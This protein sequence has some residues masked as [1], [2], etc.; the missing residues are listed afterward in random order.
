MRFALEA[1]RVAARARPGH[2]P[3]VVA[4]FAER[5]AARRYAPGLIGTSQTELSRLQIASGRS[6]YLRLMPTEEITMHDIDR[7]QLEY[8]QEA[9]PFQQEEFELQEFES[10]AMAGEM[11]E[12]EEIQLAHELLAVNNAAGA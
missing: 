8:S 3:A 4:A 12:Q 5:T 11:S 6:S 1:A 10:G 2:S 9:G 7:T